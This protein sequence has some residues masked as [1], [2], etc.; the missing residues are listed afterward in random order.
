MAAP[1]TS[2]QPPS[3][4]SQKLSAPLALSLFDPTQL[5]LLL[6]TKPS[7]TTPLSFSFAPSTPPQFGERTEGDYPTSTQAFVWRRNYRILGIRGVGVYAITYPEPDGPTSGDRNAH[8]LLS[9]G[10]S[11]SPSGE[12]QASCPR[13]VP[14]IHT[15]IQ[16]L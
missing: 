11:A 9:E 12:H 15:W 2:L 1:P 16:Q 10:S 14:R 8:L 3:L 13:N 5:T 6:S 4:E 7:G